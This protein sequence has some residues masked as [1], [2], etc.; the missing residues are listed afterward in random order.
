MDSLLVEPIE[1]PGQQRIAGGEY[2]TREMDRVVETDGELL[3]VYITAR[4]GLTIRMRFGA[5]I[6]HIGSFFRFTY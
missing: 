2:V 4:C 5:R 1:H 3:M 6:A